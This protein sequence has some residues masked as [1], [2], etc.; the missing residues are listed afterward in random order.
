[1]AKIVDVLPEVSGEELIYV[2]NLIQ[3]MDDEKARSFS[4]I[5]RARRKDPQTVLLLALLGFI[6]FA[7]IHRMVINQIGMGI[8]YFFT[9]G[10][11]FIGT[12]VDLVNYQK[13]AF[14][15]NRASADEA[16]AM[17]K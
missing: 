17:V 12:I 10:L 15:F 16:A 4:H 7:G 13:L 8:L 9:A 11:C 14:E 5:Y 2:Q 6:G 1:M 3:N